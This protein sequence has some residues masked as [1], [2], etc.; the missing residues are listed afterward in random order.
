MIKKSHMNYLCI[1]E[2]KKKATFSA[3]CFVPTTYSHCFYPGTN[4]LQR[5][6]DPYVNPHSPSKQK[7]Q[8]EA[9][10]NGH[11]Q[12]RT[13]A[14]RTQPTCISAHARACVIGKMTDSHRASRTSLIFGVKLLQS[15]IPP[16]SHALPPPLPLPLFWGKE[17]PVDYLTSPT[18]LP[19]RQLN[20]TWCTKN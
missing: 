13:L 14:Q 18:P 7:I 8:I 5:V 4:F 9:S 17:V 6:P 3:C 19:Q 15:L 10:P 2:I 11:I 16:P 20:G 12:S 1:K